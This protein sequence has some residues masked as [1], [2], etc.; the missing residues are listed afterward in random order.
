MVSLLKDPKK[1]DIE[2][3]LHFM[4]YTRSADKYLHKTI[5]RIVRLS[6]LRQTLQG[7]VTA[8]VFRSIKYGLE[9]VGKRFP[10]LF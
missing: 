3:V 7:I 10:K 9:K 8:G 5:K 1:C 2:E 4:A 6:S